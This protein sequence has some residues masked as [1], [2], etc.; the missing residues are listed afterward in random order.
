MF[1]KQTILFSE[2]KKSW[3]KQFTQLCYWIVE[4]GKRKKWNKHDRQQLH[5][6]VDSRQKRNHILCVQF[7]LRFL[8]FHLLWEHFFSCIFCRLCC[9]CFSLSLSLCWDSY[10]NRAICCSIESTPFMNY[11]HLWK[12]KRERALRYDKLF[13][14]YSN[15]NLVCYM[16]YYSVFSAR[17]RLLFVNVP[18]LLRF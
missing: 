8:L 7:V 11:I 12:V 10:G 17:E 13:L 6:F 18:L 2:L 16:F 15:D 1:L 14:N 5:S 9:C 3:P 4:M